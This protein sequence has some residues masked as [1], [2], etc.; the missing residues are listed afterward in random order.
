MEL[1]FVSLLIG[2]GIGA[3]GAF[4]AGFLR[5][6]GE[7]VFRAL[8]EKIWP[9]SRPENPPLVVR[10][11]GSGAPPHPTNVSKTAP[12]VGVNHVEYDA[13]QEALE[14]APPMQRDVV[15]RRY[16]G[17]RVSWSCY[18]SSAST[19]SKGKA[20]VHLSLDPRNLGRAVRCEV[21][22]DDYPELA[23]LN[24]KAPVQVEGRIHDVKLWEVALEDVHLA[25]PK[26]D[27][28]TT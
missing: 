17:L 27:Q 21:N 28:A 14:A 26:A 24:S 19:D 3:A 20:R 23:I 2:A 6:A 4:G 8:K 22:I 12:S 11:E 16:L 5:K 7:E 1:N 18:F 13:I 25:F 15:A 10:L 9:R